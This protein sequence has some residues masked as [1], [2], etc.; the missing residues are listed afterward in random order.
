MAI[1]KASS[2]LAKLKNKSQVDKKSF[3]LYLNLFCKE[4]FLRRLSASSYKNNFILKGG[5]FIY[6]LTNFKSR[7]TIDIDFVF[8]NESYESEKI[9][10]I[11]QEILVKDSQNNFIKMDIVKYQI[12]TANKKYPGVRLSIEVTIK[13]VRTAFFIDIGINDVV[14]PSPVKRLIPVLVSEYKNPEIYTYSLESTI[15]EKFEIILNLLEIN[16]RM[17]DF[18][19]IYYLFNNY[20]FV[21]ATLLKAVKSTLEN[22]N[23]YH[24][25]GSLKRICNFSDSKIMQKRWNNFLKILEISRPLFEEVI[26][27][28]ETFFNPLWTAFIENRDFNYCWNYKERIWQLKIN[29]L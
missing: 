13:N 6:T 9:K 7:P 15:A 26:G 5:M 4:E 12:I 20:N 19:D 17:K 2:L 8:I 11:I 24:D 3:Q 14:V 27:M 1:D 23:T 18:Y 28:F 10:K 29:D 25:G 16:S 21:G 22:R